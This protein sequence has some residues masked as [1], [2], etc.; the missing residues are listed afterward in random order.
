M[1]TA[2]RASTYHI[3]RLAFAADGP[4]WPGLPDVLRRYPAIRARLPGRE[5]LGG[6]YGT[7]AY[8]LHVTGLL[9][10]WPG[11]YEAHER[12]VPERF[13]LC[14]GSLRQPQSAS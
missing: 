6:P 3:P 11:T 5:H 13:A 10:H 2:T 14:A 9:R 7:L 8:I 12:L 4:T 1:C